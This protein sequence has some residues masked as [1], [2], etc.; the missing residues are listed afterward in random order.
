MIKFEIKAV[1]LRSFDNFS[2]PLACSFEDPLKNF[3][4]SSMHLE[5][6]EGQEKMV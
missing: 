6:I 5:S 1:Y 2:E 4:L 3:P